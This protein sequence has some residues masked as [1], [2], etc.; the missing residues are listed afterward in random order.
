MKKFVS[1]II[2]VFMLAFSCVNV[3]AAGINDSEQSVLNELA[4][5]VQLSEGSVSV[6]TEYINQAR[7]YFN[8]IDLTPDQASQI[9]ALIAAGRDIIAN[10]G[11]TS[12]NDLNEE[13]KSGVLEKVDEIMDVLSLTFTYDKT[14]NEYVAADKE[15]DIAFTAS[16]SVSENGEIVENGVVKTTGADYSLMPVFMA[17]AVGAV[18]SVCSA[19]VIKTRKERV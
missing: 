9:I 1:V 13:A 18:A 17:I 16:P 2:A 3:F 12:I 10:S 7:N 14:K 11:S 15:N 8:T 5:P 4:V 19:V 6:P